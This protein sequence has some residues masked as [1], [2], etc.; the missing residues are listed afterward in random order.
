MSWQKC[1]PPQPPF[2]VNGSVI[3][4]ASLT[5]R[6]LTGDV[7]V[8]GTLETSTGLKTYSTT[9]IDGSGQWLGPPGGERG[10]VGDNAIMFGV[11]FGKLD[12]VPS[13]QL[14]TYGMTS[15]GAFVFCPDL[16]KMC[17]YDGSRFTEI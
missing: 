7:I 16:K 14:G 10:D 8:P 3:A 12:L 5:G 1:N 6:E 13:S 2:V 9:T 4:D 11:F 17:V 15:T